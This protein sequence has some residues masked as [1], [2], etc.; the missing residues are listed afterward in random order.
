M[1]E[2]NSFFT[3]L[4]HSM[5]QHSDRLKK[6]R[7]FLPQYLRGRRFTKGFRPIAYTLA[8]RLELKVRK[9]V[10]NPFLEQYELGKPQRV[11]FAFAGRRAETTPLLFLEV[12]SLGGSQLYQF[13]EHRQIKEEANYNKL[14]YYYGTLGNYY[15]TCKRVPRY[16]VWFLILPDRQIERSPYQWWDPTPDYKFFHPSLKE[17]VCE[18]PYRF[19]DHLIKASARLFIKKKKEFLSPAKRKWFRMELRECQD[20]CEL[21]FITCTVDRLIMSRGKDLFD[22]CREM[23]V[24]LNW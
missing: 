17:L 16:F 11:D 14:W 19:Y 7:I 13:Y 20:V 12:E 5:E 2:I 18:S 24:P 22:P 6:G 21:V 1:I 15:T 8:K 10:Q 3:H 4:K 23:S 9:E